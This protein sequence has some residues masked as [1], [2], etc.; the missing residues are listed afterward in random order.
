MK[1]LQLFFSDKC[2][3]CY[4]VVPMMRKQFPDA[5]FYNITES[6]PNLKRFLHYRDNHPELED[7]H[8]CGYVG[9]PCAVWNGGEAVFTEFTDQEMREMHRLMNSGN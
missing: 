2:V 6:M 8:L 5:E 4:S 7:A 1:R 9:I 3:D